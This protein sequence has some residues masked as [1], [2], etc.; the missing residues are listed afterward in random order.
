ME[1]IYLLIIDT[2]EG[3]LKNNFTVVELCSS[4]CS[5]KIFACV[6]QG[7]VEFNVNMDL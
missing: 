7:S 4:L 2:F 5:R 6:L 3:D 1:T